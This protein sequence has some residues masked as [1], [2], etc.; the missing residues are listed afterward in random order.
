MNSKTRKFLT[1]LFV[2]IFATI[3]LLSSLSPVF[4]GACD[5]NPCP[6]GNTCVEVGEDKYSCCDDTL[7]GNPQSAKSSAPEICELSSV[8]MNVFN[9]IIAAFPILGLAVLLFGAFVWATAGA[10]PQKVEIAKK[11][12]TY[13]VIGLVAGLS[14]IVIL[15]TL[16]SML[17]SDKFTLFSSKGIMRVDFCLKEYEAGDSTGSQCATD[18]TA[19]GSS[20][21][22][23]NQSC[24]YDGGSQ[25]CVSK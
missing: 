8:I 11:T 20:C 12:L 17:I 22:N 21:C 3:F 4:A 24:V 6:E 9:M 7:C 13:G 16:E 19:C 5:S 10:D 25:R 23:S 18:Q 14:S 15:A 2:G 1:F